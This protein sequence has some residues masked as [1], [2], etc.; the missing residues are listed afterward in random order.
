MGINLSIARL[1]AVVAGIVVPTVYNNSGDA[2]LGNAFLVGFIVCIFS[3][4][5]AIGIVWLDRKSELE[6]GNTA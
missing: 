4:F 6:E 3:L 1:G 2:G 5:N